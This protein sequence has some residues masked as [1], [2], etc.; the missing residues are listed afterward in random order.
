M[1]RYI[2]IN[3]VLDVPYSI[4]KKI[5]DLSQEI[6]KKSNPYFVLDNKNYFP[7]FTV[8]SPEYPD[9]KIEEISDRLE[10]VLEGQVELKMNFEKVLTHQGY[11]GLGFELT[12][13]IKRLH[14]AIVDALNPLRDGHLRKKYQ[15]D[16]Y[17]MKLSQLELDNISKYGYPSAMNLYHPH[18]TI[19]RL[20]DVKQAEELA[21]DIIWQDNFVINTLALYKMGEHGTC[22]E[23]IREFQLK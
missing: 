12:Q 1:S 2:R 22:I 9:N 20:K 13:D 5:V 14:F 10:A 17:K 7:H 8:Y 15:A 16:D 23:K 11:I 21:R 4:S 3:T 18:M 19:I 6:A